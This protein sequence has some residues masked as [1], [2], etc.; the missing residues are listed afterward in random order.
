MNR[1]NNSAYLDKCFARL[2][3]Y[4]VA[5][6]RCPENGQDGIYSDLTSALARA[7]RIKIEIS[8]R[9]YRRVVILTGEH[10]GKATAPDPTGAQPWK[11]VGKHTTINGRVHVPALQQHQPSAP[12]LLTAEEI[13]GIK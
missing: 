6:K 10:A 8:G 7:G 5:G 9:N 13:R 4:A 11:I 3:A 12:R 1:A 2:V